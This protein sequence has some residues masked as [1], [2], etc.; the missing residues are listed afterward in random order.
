MSNAQ[1]EVIY[2]G[3]IWKPTITQIL[4]AVESDLLGRTFSRFHRNNIKS[5]IKN[6]LEVNRRVHILSHI[7]HQKKKI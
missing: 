4:G 7:S 3:T 2:A 6:I 1:I 5:S